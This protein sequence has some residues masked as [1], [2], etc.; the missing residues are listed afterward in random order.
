MKDTSSPHAAHKLATIVA[1]HSASAVA[2]NIPSWQ[3]S[4]RYTALAL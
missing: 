2:I 3:P 4:S 1:L